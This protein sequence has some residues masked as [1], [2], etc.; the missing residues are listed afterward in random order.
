[1]LEMAKLDKKWPNSY[2]VNG[3][4][5]QKVAQKTDDGEFLEN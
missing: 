5:R 4:S 1:M 3:Q 2:A